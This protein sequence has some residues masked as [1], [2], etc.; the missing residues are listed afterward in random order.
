M[1][2][3]T[4]RIE[5]QEPLLATAL[6]GDPN[7]SES[8]PYIPG[9]T[10]RGMVIG[11]YL[12]Q[13]SKIRDPARDD[14]CRR[15]FFNGST[16]YL[17]A[18]PY[19]PVIHTRCLPTPRSLRRF[20]G[21]QV[22]EADATIFDTSNED[23]DFNEQ[24]EQEKKDSLKS[25]DSPFCRFSDESKDVAFYTPERTLTIHI[26]R[27]PRRGR[28]HRQEGE[29]FR[30]EALATGQMF[31]G[32]ILLN[33]ETDET[34]MSEILTRLETCWLG[35]SRS[36]GYG[37]VKL[38]YIQTRSTWRETGGSSPALSAGCHCT[39]TLLSDAL[40]YGDNGQPL[41]AI[42]STILESILGVPLNLVSEHTFTSSVLHGGFNRAWQLPI[43]QS[44]MLAAGSV[45]AF[46]LEAPLDAK[47]VNSLETQGIGAR[48]AEGFGRVAF[49]WHDT[50][51]MTS[52]G[53]EAL[54]ESPSAEKPLSAIEQQMAGNMA[55]RLLEAHIER[56]ILGY[57]KDI[58]KE[59]LNCFP[60]PTQL[61]RIRTL[62]RQ[63]IA[64]GEAGVGE[65]YKQFK[66]FKPAASQQFERA[67]IS[68]RDGSKKTLA[69]WICDLLGGNTDLG[70]VLDLGES[71][72]VVAG[73]QATID[74]DLAAR[75]TL[76]LLAAVM[77]RA[78]R[79]KQQNEEGT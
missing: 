6:Q 38:S 25:V 30:Y 43:P 28:S 61:N 23:W 62:A 16:R 27:D 60:N 52:I 26:Q 36:A 71:T 64:S 34:L 72:V 5:L 8:L 75:T 74:R 40:L 73:E 53:K 65:V 10:I 42:E 76:R 57:V 24:R 22:T 19:D 18:Y 20:K 44:Y 39:M 4:Y 13:H 33:N 29:I 77:E 50:M 51:E 3:I 31:Q 59:D 2:T 45:I 69:D 56:A 47:R 58:P 49:N 11:H 35:R 78:V 54:K 17:H 15:L 48:R 68:N 66:Q 21:E 79:L 37:R 12:K 41:T 70:E 46:K 9:S 63:N 14:T 7:S 67:R 55:R 1:K 32:A